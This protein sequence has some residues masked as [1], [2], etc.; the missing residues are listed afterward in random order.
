MFKKE[1][2][3]TRSGQISFSI[4]LAGS[5]RR[6]DAADSTVLGESVLEGTHFFLVG[7]GVGVS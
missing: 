6:Q 5:G 7:E 4:I 1:V 3:S 2:K